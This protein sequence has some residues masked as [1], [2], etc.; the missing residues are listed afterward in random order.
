[1]DVGIDVSELGD[2]A[3]MLSRAATRT[4]AERAAAL[5]K[6]AHQVQS[7]ATAIASTY[8]KGTG[9]LASS[10]EVGGTPVSRR[11]FADLR[12]AYFLE[13]GSPNTGPPRPWLTG[14]A[15]KGARE[16]FDE[17]GKMGQIW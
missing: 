1:M 10:I 13:F 11:I 16:L 7:E 6:V 12:E 8:T 14:P 2:L 17:L 3:G 5:D 4:H 15:E 9:A